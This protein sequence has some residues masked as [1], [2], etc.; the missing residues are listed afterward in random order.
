MKPYHEMTDDE[1]SAFGREV[2]EDLT[3]RGMMRHGRPLTNVEMD[4]AA[5]WLR[6][7]RRKAKQFI[8]DEL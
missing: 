3:C 5:T 8:E 6:E 2:A 1:K 7:Q 4:A